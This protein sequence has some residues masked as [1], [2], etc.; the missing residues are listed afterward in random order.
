MLETPNTLNIKQDYLISPDFKSHFLIQIPTHIVLVMA[1]L[2]MA[3]LAMA[4][5]VDGK[6]S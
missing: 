2:V 6:T 1:V 5:T 4:S 3:V